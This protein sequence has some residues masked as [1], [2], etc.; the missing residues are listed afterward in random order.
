MPSTKKLTEKILSTE[1]KFNVSTEKDGQFILMSPLAFYNWLEAQ[2][3][4]RKV[5]RIQNHH[6]WK[7]NYSHFDGDNHFSLAKGMKRS[8][9]KRKFSDIAQ[10]ITIYPD[11]TIMVCRPLS[12]VPAGIYGAN[13]GSICIEHIGNFDEGGDEMTKE[14]RY[15]IAYCNAVLLKKFGLEINSDSVVYHH[16]WTAGGKRKNGVDAAK[17]CPGNNFFGGNKVSDAEA[18]LYPKIEEILTN[19]K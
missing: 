7:P 12:K 11:G 5:V 18:N 17:S 15:A 2:T 9:L 1:D 6:T 16:W 13:T 19:L 14:Q 10:N 3:I 4:K 8:H